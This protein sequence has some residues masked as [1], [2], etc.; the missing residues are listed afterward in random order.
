MSQSSQ[1]STLSKY[2]RELALD[3][4]KLKSLTANP[5]KEMAQANLSNE[6]KNVLFRGNEKEITQILHQS[7]PDLAQSGIIVVVVL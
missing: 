4:S 3:P 2:L 7:N 5:H 1:P 6:E